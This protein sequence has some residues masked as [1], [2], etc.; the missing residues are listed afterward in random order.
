MYKMT[1]ST[2]AYELLREQDLH[3][4]VVFMLTEFSQTAGTDINADYHW[5]T[6]T[7]EDFLIAKLK[8]PEAFKYI[9][10]RKI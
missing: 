7:E 1:I 10:T 3:D 6:I 4:R 8:Y 5:A 2:F 9:T